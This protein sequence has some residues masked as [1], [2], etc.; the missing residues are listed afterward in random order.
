MKPI[1]AERNLKVNDD[2]TEETSVFRAETKELELWRKVKKLGSLLGDFEDMKRRTSLAV[3]AQ[4]S[5]E[6]MFKKSKASL[7]EKAKVYK[8][9]VKRV[10]TYNY[11][12][13]GLS[14]NEQDH[15]DR[16]HRKQLRRLCPSLKEKSNNEVYEICKD[17][18]ISQ[19]MKI[20]RWN[21]FGHVLRLPRDTPAQ[22][23]MD[24][25][26]ETP[27]HAEKFKGQSRTTLPTVINRDIIEANKLNRLPTT[28]FVTS[29]DLSNLRSIAADKNQWKEIVE[30]ICGVV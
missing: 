27:M 19:D 26:F 1:L 21:M 6:E 3:T 18:E 15:L 22:L 29:G 2:K 10:L 17:R 30:R 9:V 20:A 13:W 14:K 11:S 23:A 24:F 8:S 7:E 4:K 16:F 5:I 25:Y 28:Q 12:T